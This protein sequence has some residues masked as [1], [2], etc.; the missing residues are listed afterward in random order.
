MM[1]RWCHT[2]RSDGDVDEIL[3]PFP[4]CV[5]SCLPFPDEVGDGG[6]DEL[7]LGDRDWIARGAV[8]GRLAMVLT[9]A[10]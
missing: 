9:T 6:K 8:R 5:S 4:E 3:Y 10:E 7:V 1:R 2:S